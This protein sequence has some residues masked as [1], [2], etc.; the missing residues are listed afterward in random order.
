MGWRLNAFLNKNF[1][2]VLGVLQNFTV[3]EWIVTFGLMYI[4]FIVLIG[5]SFLYSK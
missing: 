2:R 5:A 3:M 4:I 1:P